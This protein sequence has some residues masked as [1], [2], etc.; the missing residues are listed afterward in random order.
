[1][2]YKELTQPPQDIALEIIRDP[3]RFTEYFEREYSGIRK[4]LLSNLAAGTD[5]LIAQSDEQEKLSVLRKTEE[6]FDDKGYGTTGGQ[7]I[8]IGVYKP[9]AFDAKFTK[10]TE[11]GDAVL[12]MP[13]LN[14]EQRAAW[15]EYLTSIPFT[16]NRRALIAKAINNIPFPIV[17]TKYRPN[18]VP[19]AA[20]LEEAKRRITTR[21]LPNIRDKDAQMALGQRYTAGIARSSVTPEWFT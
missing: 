21:L 12:S 11:W 6:L 9:F 13:E 10:K 16:E 7:I 8:Q 5:N 20:E 15:E 3:I 1:M 19:L 18:N 14:D 17:T 4:S 2:D